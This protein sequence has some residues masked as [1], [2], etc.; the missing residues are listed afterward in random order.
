MLAVL[1]AHSGKNLATT[2]WLK[3][4]VD[5]FKSAQSMV[6]GLFHIFGSSCREPAGRN[7]SSIDL[8]SC[9][10]SLGIIRDAFAFGT[11]RLERGSSSKNVSIM[12]VF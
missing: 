12:V 4:G 9:S 8:V 2:S 7:I 11:S 1:V 6:N 3:A 10:G 5:T